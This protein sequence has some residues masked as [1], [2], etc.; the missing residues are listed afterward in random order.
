VSE[1]GPRSWVAFV[2]ST[3]LFAAVLFAHNRHLLSEPIHEESDSAANSLL[4]LKAKRLELLH[5][6]YSRMCFF[7]PGPALLY[8]EAAGEWLLYDTLHVVP[9]PHNGQIAAILLL[10]AM[11]AGAAVACVAGATGSGRAG[12]AS[13]AALLVYFSREAQLG[14]HWFAN[15][16]MVLYLAFPFAAAA[17]ASGRP[18]FLG[19]LA[20]T[21]SLAVHSHVSFMAFVLPI[22]TYAVFR[23]WRAGEYRLRTLPAAERRH[24]LVFAAVIALFVLPIA[25]HTVRHFPGEIGRYLSYSKP[26]SAGPRTPADVANFVARCM[27]NDAPQ[28]VPLLAGLGAAA[29]LAV[30]T[31]PE[32]H[33]RFVRQL[34]LVTAASVAV[35]AYYAARGVD[36]YQHSYVGR[37]F[38][39]AVAT[40]WVLV[41]VR[42]AALSDAPI[43]RV[44]TVAVAVA[45]IAWAARSPAFSNGYHGSPQTYELAQRIADDPRWADGSPAVTMN[46]GGW[47]EGTAL[48]LHLERRGKRV[49]VV[50][51]LYDILLSDRFAPDGRPLNARWHID[52]AGVSDPRDGVRAVFAEVNGVAFREME[53]RVPLGTP[54]AL[55]SDGRAG[56][57]KGV[58]GWF[59]APHTRFLIP[60]AREAELLVDLAPCATP[61]ARLTLTAKAIGP[62]GGPQPVEVSV[63]GE[64]V[65]RVAFAEGEPQAQSLTVPAVL[66]RESPVRVGFTFPDA[67]RYKG[68]RAPRVLYSVHFSGMTVT[69]VSVGGQP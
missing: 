24:W 55:S 35:M 42:V 38:A 41:A 22:S 30:L 63:N 49:W 68:W 61:E 1:R 37:F 26:Q 17:V 54:I 58:S 20:L 65:G 51:R 15:V 23:A 45:V 59:S 6:H 62:T 47:I 19:L 60:A 53:T 11:L 29:L 21:G 27:T 39:T 32:P 14:S 18:S 48:V 44:L 66:N 8:V 12:L 31:C 34:G 7:H 9:A 4:V 69:P 2:A 13:A 43:F 16:F 36:D 56:G 50:E 40:A 25:L 10:H 3:A 5:G 52:C 28:R 33:R 46:D 57:V 64:P 67:A